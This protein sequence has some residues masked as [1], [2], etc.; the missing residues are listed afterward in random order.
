MFNKKFFCK[1]V[2]V[3]VLM[4]SAEFVPNMVDLPIV[5]AQ[6]SVFQV[7]KEV[8]KFMSLGNYKKAIEIC[9][10][11]LQNYP[12]S[13]LLYFHRS[14]CYSML[15]EYDKALADIDKAIELDSY[16]LRHYESKA[17]IYRDMN[18]YDKVVEIYT[19]LIEKNS[20]ELEYYRQRG[21]IYEKL[22]DNQHATEDYKKYLSMWSK[23]DEIMDFNDYW[24]RGNAYKY[25]KDY[26]HAIDDYTK[27]LAFKKSGSMRN[28]YKSRGECYEAL[29]EKEK[30][31]ADF[32]EVKLLGG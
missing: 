9:T 8:I 22:K 24:F 2:A 13:D 20:Y 3:G 23:P 10:E 17:S 6:D 26:Q 1:M 11:G 7:S 14:S 4:G 28:I 18:K 19:Q 15:K 32:I 16:N 27:A 12:D 31:K 30:A 25:I 5:Y 21:I 29:G